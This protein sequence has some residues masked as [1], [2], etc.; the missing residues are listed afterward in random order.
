MSHPLACDWCGT[1]AEP[2]DYK[3][4]EYHAKKIGYQIP[5]ESSESESPKLD[6]ERIRKEI[7]TKSRLRSFPG[8]LF[9]L[10]F[11]PD[12]KGDQIRVI[13]GDMIQ[14]LDE[15]DRLRKTLAIKGIDS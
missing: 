1:V 9:D 8:G 4:C 5:T 15:I 14:L 13:R 2:P 11:S 10:K 6:V 3:Y 12:N 7:T